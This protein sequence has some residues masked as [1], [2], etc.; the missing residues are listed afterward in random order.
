MPGGGP[1]TPKISTEIES[2]DQIEAAVDAVREL[3]ERGERDYT[4]GVPVTAVATNLEIAETSARHALEKA[5]EGGLL[6]VRTPDDQS[7]FDERTPRGYI[8]AE[9]R[10]SDLYITDDR[11]LS[12]PPSS[13]L[14]YAV[15]YYEGSC[16]PIELQQRTALS[17]KSIRRATD[18]LQEAGVLVER[19]S[20][21]DTRQTVYSLDTDSRARS[22]PPTDH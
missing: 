21:D 15:F 14:L 9:A 5:V 8:P 22:G 17:T 2:D 12:L 1:A 11:V 10:R 19:P 4:G 20:P 13:K 16:T 18:R 3:Y 6:V 7:P